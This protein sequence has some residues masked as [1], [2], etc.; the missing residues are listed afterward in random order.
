MQSDVPLDSSVE[1]EVI[2]VREGKAESVKVLVATEVPLTIEVN[3]TEIVTL[4]CTPK[5][6]KEL[7]YGFLC[8]SGII[9]EA[10]EVLS[11]TCDEAKWVARVK[12]KDMPD[13]SMLSK[14]LY[15]SGCGKGVMYSSQAEIAARHPLKTS[16]K[17]KK[18]TLILLMRW[19]QGSSVLFKKSGGVHTAALSKKEKI[20]QTS[21]DD[22]GRHNAVDKVIGS[23]LLQGVDFT[24]TILVC[25]G[26]TSS[27]MLHKTKR[28]GIPIS[29]SRGAPTHQTILLAREMGVTVVGFARGGGFTVYS[30]PDRITGLK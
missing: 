22:V 3:G 16:F 13:L 26:R 27:D 30:F 2:K 23:G 1:F 6:V 4:M 21:I 24:E 15:T 12:V 14:R 8:T 9:Q 17:V 25:S 10:E 19:L 18:E 7:C 28:C 5:H 29:V 11:Y 20:P